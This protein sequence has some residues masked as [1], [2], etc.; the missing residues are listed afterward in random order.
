MRVLTGFGL[1]FH[2]YSMYLKRIKMDDYQQQLEP[3]YKK[4]VQAYERFMQDT[5]EGYE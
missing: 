4:Q 3:L 1:I 5:Y 2:M